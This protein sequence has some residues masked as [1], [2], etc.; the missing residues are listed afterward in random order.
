MKKKILVIGGG[1]S[2]M[3]AAITAAEKKCD[4]TIYEKSDRIGK[5]ILVTG[6][7][8]CNLANRNLALDCYFTSQPNQ[9]KTYFDEFDF[10]DTI[11][12]FKECGLLLKDKNGYIYPACEQASMVLDVLRNRLRQLHVVIKTQVNVEQIVE[13][14]NKG[15]SVLTNLGNEFFDSVIIACGSYAG[16]KD[17]KSVTGYELAR[18]L[19]HHI[20]PL[21]PALVQIVC[22]ETYFKALSGVRVDAN[23]TLQE[24]DTILA[25]ERGELQ[26][27]DYGISGIPVFQFSRM[28]AQNLDKKKTLKVAIDFLPEYEKE[29]WMI[30]VSN[31]LLSYQGEEV[32][33]FFTGLLHKKINALL[34]KLFSL[35]PQDKIGTQNDEKLKKACEY[36]KEFIV[37]PVATKS[38]E[39]AQTCAGGI[40]LLELDETLQSK[41]HPDI[42]FCGEMVDVDGKCGGYNLQW[43]WTSGYIAGKNASTVDA[44]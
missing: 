23:L 8:K 1:A 2:G 35:K 33:T 24:N 38:F 15:I 18:K 20:M 10:E 25:I 44:K 37:T 17:I 13:R 39:S 7:G 27:T 43:A 19:G 21:Y 40:D 5:K 31:R 16:V 28:I 22:E 32:E 6:N 4:V 34:M 12:F 29:E 36:I 3:M 14:E 11:L 30:F 26:L 42:Y 9:L 41:I